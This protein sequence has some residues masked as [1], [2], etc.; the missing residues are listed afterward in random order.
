MI[1]NRHLLNVFIEPYYEQYIEVNASENELGYLV[2]D[3]NENNVQDYMSSDREIYKA[4]DVVGTWLFH[5]TDK[6]KWSIVLGDFDIENK[7]NSINPL[8]LKDNECIYYKIGAGRESI[9]FDGDTAIMTNFTLD[10]HVLFK[11]F[12]NNQET[13]NYIVTGKNIQFTENA[14]LFN[15]YCSIIYYNY[16]Q[17]LENHNI[18]LYFE[19]ATV[20]L[21]LPTDYINGIDLGSATKTAFNKWTL[22]TPNINL[23][24]GAYVKIDNVFTQ[25]ANVTSQSTFYVTD[26]IEGNTLTL[27]PALCF[28]SI[29]D[30]FNITNNDEY[31]EIFKLNIMNPFRKKIK[32]KKQLQFTQWIAE[33]YNQYLYSFPILTRSLG[34]YVGDKKFRIVVINEIDD[35]IECFTNASIETEGLKTYGGD[36]N[37]VNT[38][39]NFQDK[40]TIVFGNKLLYGE[41][42]YGTYYYGG[43]YSSKEV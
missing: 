3:K 1:E 35:K 25:I 32:Q 41:G 24:V 8:V 36:V 6:S 21:R 39:V 17:T 4:T 5:N 19:Y 16:D 7:G 15:N 31:L 13:N 14:R 34:S 33:N 40:I 23:Q 37:K 12:L 22:T 11:V 38:S 30:D 42:Y 9:N 20:S 26:D 18:K 43:Y 10:T 27:Y 29:N 2:Y 28:I